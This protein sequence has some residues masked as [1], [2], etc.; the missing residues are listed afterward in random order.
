MIRKIKQDEI[1]LLYPFV[2]R[3]LLD[4]ELPLLKT[5][6]GDT[7]NSIINEAMESPNY[8]YGFE[9]AWVCE[10]DKQIVGVLFGYPGEFTSMV[11]GPFEVALINHVLS[12]FEFKPGN[13]T[14]PGEWYLDA[15]VVAPIF[16]RKGIGRRMLQIIDNIAKDAGYYAIG[17]NCPIDNSVAYNLYKEVGFSEY[18]KHL[19]GEKIYYHMTKEL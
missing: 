5:V 18:T 17:L 3:I 2:Y 12:P 15:L 13:E 8:R 1:P 6:S 11:D 14:Y 16:R 9:H 4:M 19:L 7:L 10:Q